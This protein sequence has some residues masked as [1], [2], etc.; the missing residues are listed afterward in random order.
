MRS[1]IYS[2]VAVAVLGSSSAIA[3]PEGISGGPVNVPTEGIIDGVFIH[4]L[5]DEEDAF[6]VIF[7]SGRMMKFKKCST[8]LYYYDTDNPSKHEMKVYFTSSEDDIDPT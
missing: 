8:D 6:Y 7:Q 3:Q 4:Y 2:I 1:L 5:G